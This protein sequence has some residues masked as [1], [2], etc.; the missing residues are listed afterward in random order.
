MPVDIAAEHPEPFTNKCVRQNYSKTD[1]NLVFGKGETLTLVS[2][3]PKLRRT[4]QSRVSDELGA[5]GLVGAAAGAARASAKAAAQKVAAKAQP[6]TDSKAKASVVASKA[7]PKAK[8]R[9]KKH[10][11]KLGKPAAGSAMKSNNKRKKVGEE[12]HDNLDEVPNPTDAQI[13]SAMIAGVSS[14]VDVSCGS[15]IAGGVGDEKSD[16]DLASEG[17]DG[18]HEGGVSE[19]P[20]GDSEVKVT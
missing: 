12:A 10:Q 18:E 7:A 5:T 20:E 8:G 3:F 15:I 13:Q 1:A 11:V 16:A 4:L 2:L 17:A 19:E 14:M 6:K 9:A